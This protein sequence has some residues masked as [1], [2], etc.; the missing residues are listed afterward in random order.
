MT[1]FAVLS[2]GQGG[3]WNLSKEL[4]LGR[5]SKCIHLLLSASR[6]A[7]MCFTTSLS[8]SVPHSA[9]V[10]SA[11]RSGIVHLFWYGRAEGR[12]ASAV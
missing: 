8:V 5:A 9:G 4:P 12:T 1:D 11:S 2:G 3:D 7:V 6:I 10:I